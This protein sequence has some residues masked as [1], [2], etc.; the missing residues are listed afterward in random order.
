MKIQTSRKAGFTLVEI[1]IV[2]AI[3]GLLAAIAIPNFIKARTTSQAN[4]CINNLRQIDGAIQQ[5]ALEKGQSASATVTSSD[6]TPYLG[7]GTAGEFPTCPAKGTYT[8][9]K[10]SEKPT[11]SLSGSTPPHALPAP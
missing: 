1:M 8:L 2:V 4:A 9:T 3:I 10:V 6:V 5:W 11:C 7:R